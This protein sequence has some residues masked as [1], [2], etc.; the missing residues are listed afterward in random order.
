MSSQKPKYLDS[1]VCGWWVQAL[2]QE[3]REIEQSRKLSR[4]TISRETYLGQNE[5]WSTWS[6]GSL[7][8]PCYISTNWHGKSK[9]ISPWKQRRFPMSSDAQIRQKS[10]HI[11]KITTHL[12]FWSNFLPGFLSSVGH[13]PC[14]TCYVDELREFGVPKARELGLSTGYYKTCVTNC[15]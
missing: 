13:H 11:Y 3:R 7:K 2:I 1:W 4:K 9:E 12:Q 5:T 15:E 6:V 10:Y 14:R 8:R